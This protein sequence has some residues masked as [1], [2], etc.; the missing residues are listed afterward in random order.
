MHLPGLLV[1]S[2]GTIAALPNLAPKAHVKA[3]KLF[4][5]G[6]IAEAQ[7]LQNIFAHADWAVGKIGGVAG[8]KLV[9][10]KYFGYGTGA[11]RGPL[12]VVGEDR[13][14]GTDG[15]WIRKLVEIEKSL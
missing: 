5:E 8:L 11:V 6:K 14:K 7:E 2:Q 4:N 9:V 15:E 13:L 12:S 3:F 10:S 1:G